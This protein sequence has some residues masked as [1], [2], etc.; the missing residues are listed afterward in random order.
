MAHDITS[1]QLPRAPATL[2]DR[3]IAPTNHVRRLSAASL[4]ILMLTISACIPSR[5]RTTPTV[6]PTLTRTILSSGLSILPEDVRLLAPTMPAKPAQADLG[7]EPFYQICMACHGDRGQGLTEE[8]RLVW[9]EDFNCWKSK[10]HAP[11]HPPYGF[12]LP[13]TTPAIIGPGALLAYSNAAELHAKI[14]NT[15]PWWNPKSLSTEQRWQLTAYLLRQRGKLPQGITLDDGTA[16]IIKLHAV[17]APRID[18]RPAVLVLVL[19]LIIAASMLIISSSF[20]IWI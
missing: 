5:G 19:L 14:A 9:G 2:T 3:R 8:W 6:T 15:M 17:P 20:P 1:P 10:C 4:L 7:A 11:N 12:D 16:P 13:H 18:E